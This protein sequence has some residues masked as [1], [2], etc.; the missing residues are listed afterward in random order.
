MSSLRPTPT[1]SALRPRAR[2]GLLQRIARLL[3]AWW[4]H[5]VSFAISLL[6]T[7]SAL[8]IYLG[9]FVGEA[10]YA[11][12][13]FVQKLE[14]S[15][16]DTRFR[17]R[18]SSHAQ[19]DPR[20][21]IVDI[22]QRSQ[23]VLGRWPF[24][25]THFANM[26]DALREDG[27][28]VVAFDITFGKAEEINKPV[29]EIHDEFDELRRRGANM[30]PR[31]AAKLKQL[32]AKYDPDAHFARAIE[33]F[34]PVVLGNYFLYTDS[35]LVGMEDAT[36][37][38][39]AAL[40]SFFPF[41]RVQPLRPE[42]Y[43]QDFAQLLA[44]DARLLLIP[45]GAQANLETFS[46]ALSGERGTTGF[47]NVPPDTDGVVRNAVLAIPY[48][49]SKNIDEWDLY[50]SM[51]VQAVRLFLGLPAQDTVL[52]FGPRGIARIEFGKALEL[53]TDDLGR[54]AINYRGP[55]HTYRYSSIADVVGRTFPPGLFRDKIVLV[56]AS[57]TGIGDNRAT[58]FG[59]LNFPGVE[60]HA[61]IIDNML[62]EDF[63]QRGPRQ[64]AWDLAFIFLFGVP[65]G[66]WLGLT[67]PQ[68]MWFGLWLAAPFLG[69]VYAAFLK[70][71]W[72]NLT[73][74]LFTLVANVSLVALYRVIVEERE[75]RKVRGS[76]QQ[77]LSPEV[78]RRLLERP[79][80]VQPRKTD[81]TIMFSDIRNFT[82][83]SEALDAQDLALLL[84]GYLSDMTRIIFN[85]QGT[86]DK[87]IGDAVMAFW[88][89]PFEEADHPVRACHA[90]LIMMQRVAELREE[91]RA[92]GHPLLDIGIGLN[93]GTASVGNM[94]S[95]LRYGYTA[96]GDAVNLS[97]RLEGLNKEYRTHI[98]VGPAT[99]EA[100][101]D[102]AFLYRELDLIRVQGKLKPVIIYELVALK[103][104]A[105]EHAERLGA[106]TNARAAY[107]RRE[108]LEAQKMFQD[109]LDRWPDDGP[110]RTYWKRCQDYLFE[111][112]TESWDGVFVMTH[113]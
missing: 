93:S 44:N 84:N 71:W 24:T 18:G 66:L 77:Y 19:A 23:E 75:K 20:I 52:Q 42:S 32:E 28:K 99:Y 89:A 47:F 17:Y 15:T 70:G 96:M 56:G 86:L 110:S 97:S 7:V 61:N 49:R 10:P 3:R 95:Q 21:V 41:P 30:D 39:Y 85:T 5:K 38:H 2:P 29:R 12:F 72:L 78:I 108:W 57:A 73:I 54:A 98:L 79:Q 102:S 45:K 62:H 88:G 83:I 63:L 107:L 105:A 33:R 81:V 76:F 103:E 58:P 64:R 94:G 8:V 109:V 34:G 101:R 106:F 16:L 36:L 60:I 43:Q 91:W 59:G 111:A 14:S 65:L 51:D 1:A 113:K 31:F 40:L 9:T 112:P 11:L 48:G 22:D 68:N 46:A 37:D 25:R 104:A 6:L 26:L 67:R 87:Y 53:A 55:D 82:S 100:T 50:A 74:P 4:S 35:D 90:A 69:G 13:T 92:A 80:L 27:A